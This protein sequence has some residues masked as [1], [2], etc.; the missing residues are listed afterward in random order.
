MFPADRI[1]TKDYLHGVPMHLLY[2]LYPPGSQARR[3]VQPRGSICHVPAPGIFVAFPPFRL[4]HL[5]RTSPA[6]T[7]PTRNRPTPSDTSRAGASA[8]CGLEFPL[9]ALKG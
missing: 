9:D 4:I 7:A 1:R 3:I 6:H 2:L 5:T 8:G